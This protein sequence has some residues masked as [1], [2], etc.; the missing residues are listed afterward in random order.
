MSEQKIVVPEEMLKAAWQ[1][2]SGKMKERIEVGDHNGVPEL[3]VARISVEAALRWLT[4]NPIEP[5]EEQAQYMYDGKNGVGHAGTI[6]YCMIEWQRRM[7][8]AP[9]LPDDREMTT[10]DCL[11]CKKSWKQQLRDPVALCVYCQSSNTKPICT[12]SAVRDFSP[13]PEV[14]EIKDLLR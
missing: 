13:E 10:Y 11:N 2:V 5:T 9:E 4:E 7:F 1:A 14:P 12:T 8:L 3:Y 6:R